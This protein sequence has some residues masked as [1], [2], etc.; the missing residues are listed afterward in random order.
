MSWSALAQ[1]A[2]LSDL[3]QDFCLG[4]YEG[5]GWRSFQHDATWGIAVNGFLMAE[6]LFADKSVGGKKTSSN[7]KCLLS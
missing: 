7:T 3:K 2:R 1:R 6:R 5:Q 4:H